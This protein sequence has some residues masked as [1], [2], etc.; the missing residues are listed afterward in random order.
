MKKTL[1]SLAAVLSLAAS[2]HAQTSGP[3]TGVPIG[4]A[5]PSNYIQSEIRV[6]NAAVIWALTE[7]N[8]ANSLVRSY[9]RSVDG[10]TTWTGGNLAIPAGLSASSITAVD[11]NTA[12]ISAYASTAGAAQG[13][14]K[15]T[16]GGVTWNRQTTASFSGTDAF[17]NGVHFWDANNGVCFGDAN[18]HAVG[19]R[20]EIYTTTDGGTTWT[21]NNAAPAVTSLSEYGL[22]HSYFVRGNTIWHGGAS[23][24]GSGVGSGAKLYKS[25][26][27][28]VTWTAA[29][30][31][32]TNAVS[33][34]A[35]TDDLRGIMSEGLDLAATTDGG[36]NNN[37]IATTGPFRAWGLDNV[38]G[39]NNTYISVGSEVATGATLANVGTS[40]SRDAGAT[41]TSLNSGVFQYEIDMFSASV[42]YVGGIGGST[43]S[44]PIWRLNTAI[45]SSRNSA[46][47]KGV[48]KVYPNPSN[49]GV[50]KLNVNAPSTK[51]REV[52]VT[53]ALGRVVYTTSLNA[54]AV[55]QDVSLDL[56]KHKAGLYTLRL[57]TEQGTAVEKL[58]IQ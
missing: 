55:G 3:W 19:A 7:E 26:N 28:G 57:E 33:N 41:W 2:A 4:T 17:I 29:G 56:S 54:T 15:T 48:L 52:T 1:L 36:T 40:I 27:R 25:T 13:V 16:D 22:V 45:L 35:F 30:T 37:L 12:W 31:D 21:R 46:A 49:D 14:Y 5:L 11:A 39:L 42:G 23:D 51:T 53:D 8:V 44:A 50:F 6:V 43:T 58:V 20:L 10:G 9:I 47:L 24:N 32:L 18:P 38:P 34:I